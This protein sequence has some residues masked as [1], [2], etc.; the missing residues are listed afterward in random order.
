MKTKLILNSGGVKRRED[1]KKQFHQEMVKGLSLKL[2]I[3]ICTFAQGREFWEGKF[4]GYSASIKEDLPEYDLSFTLA[5]PDDFANQIKDADIIYF[6][7]AMTT[8]LHIGW[9]NLI[10]AC[11][12]GKF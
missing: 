6:N 8:C 4:P 3:L 1:L 5:M 2:N 12:M 11:L 9:I 10:S 7:V